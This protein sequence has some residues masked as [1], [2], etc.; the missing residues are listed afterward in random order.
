MAYL[1]QNDPIA[2]ANSAIRRFIESLPGGRITPAVRP[3]Y[4]QLVRDYFAAVKHR[5]EQ[6]ADEPEP[7]RL[8]A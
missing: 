6:R 8:A 2:Q 3:E 1:H 4:E 5:D 7:P